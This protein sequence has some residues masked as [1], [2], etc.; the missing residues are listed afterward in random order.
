LTSTATSTTTRGTTGI[1]TRATTAS[2]HR[3]R[4][5]PPAPENGARALVVVL[6]WTT[7]AF[8]GLYPSLLPFPAVILVLLAIIYR[9]WEHGRA[10]LPA[11]DAWLWITLAVIAIQLVPLPGP[12]IDVVSPAARPAQERIQLAAPDALPISLDTSRTAKAL[13]ATAAAILVFLTARRIFAT[14]GVRIVARGVAIIGMLLSTIALAQNATARGLMYWRWRP[15]D[16]GPDP[17]GPFVNR[18]HFATWAILAIP[19]CIGYLVAHSAA[20]AHH[21]RQHV[22]LRRRLVTFF[23][24]RAMALTS[25]VGLLLV[26]LVM[27]MSRSGLFGLAAATVAGLALALRHEGSTGRA[28]WWLTGAIVVALAL[29]LAELSPA[30]FGERISA[31][32]ISAGN[33]WV[34]WQDTMPILR[35]F[36]LTGTGAGT[37]LTSMLVYQRSAP[38]W[39]FNQAHNHYL[40]VAS[41]GGLLIGI[42]V[43]AALACLAR[44]GWMAVTADKSG[45]YW[46]RAGALCSLAGLAAQSAWETGLTM[47]ANAVLAALAAAI[48]VHD[49][50]PPARR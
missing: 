23:D 9:P 35:D 39:L 47:P 2:S 18:N 34:I 37:Y 38:G 26:A 3:A 5:S 40:Q 4:R 6:G 14:G 36:W 24:G 11:L 42:P 21:T 15:L 8:A 44:D 46:I 1:S 32:H 27:T 49:T 48:A 50:Q 12:V 19:L 22:P 29:T 30:A 20:H 25:A 43:L 7:F 45:I 10:S 17:F 16:E 33:R 13:A 31:F 28:A 41:E